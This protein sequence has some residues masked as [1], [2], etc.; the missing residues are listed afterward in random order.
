MEH[1]IACMVRLSW[2][3]LHTVAQNNLKITSLSFE[4]RLKSY[5]V[6]KMCRKT[7]LRAAQVEAQ[8]LF[9]D[10]LRNYNNG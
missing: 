7:V 6:D 1:N 8:D 9:E 2:I 5:E 3:F 4:I 10:L